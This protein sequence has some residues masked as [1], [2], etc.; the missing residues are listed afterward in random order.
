MRG[1][2][3]DP[4]LARLRRLAAAGGLA[5]FLPAV[6]ALTLFQALGPCLCHDRGAGGAGQHVPVP[7]GPAAPHGVGAA[8]PVHAHGTAPARHPAG[9]A[10]S[11]C[12]AGLCGQAVVATGPVMPPGAAAP[13]AAVF[14]FPACEQADCGIRLHHRPPVRAPPQPTA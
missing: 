4:L 9:P 12:G 7:T 5:L 3:A 11:C 14:P 6:L 10:C 1:Q 8:A 2:S 13:V